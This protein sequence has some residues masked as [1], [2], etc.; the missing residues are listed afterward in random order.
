MKI[1][2][3]ITVLLTVFVI[4]C[5]QITGAIDLSAEIIPARSISPL[6]KDEINMQSEHI[7]EPTTEKAEIE[8][9]TTEYLGKFELTAYC[10]CEICCGEY[11]V[12]RPVDEYG[13]Q[14][15]YGATGERLYQGVSIAVDPGVIPYGSSVVIEE[16]VYKAHDCGGAIDGN[17]IDVYFENH[18]DA[19][20]FGKRWSDV[21]LLLT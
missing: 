13:K 8:Q 10:S 1:T 20:A 12:G 14:I 2:L 19:V 21:Y 4:L 9:P 16:N 15:V 5:G 6:K 3:F 7:A 18:T 11:A 17:K